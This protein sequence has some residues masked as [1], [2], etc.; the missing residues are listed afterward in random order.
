M[1]CKIKEPV[2]GFQSIINRQEL[3]MWVSA[4]LKL[5]SLFFGD[6]T[7][8]QERVMPHWAERLGNVRVQFVGRHVFFLNP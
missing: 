4:T 5:V 7:S 8:R 2:S 6:L 1:L 3:K